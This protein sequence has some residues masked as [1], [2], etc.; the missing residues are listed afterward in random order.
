MHPLVAGFGYAVG[1]L[2]VI[3]GRAAVHRDDADRGHSGS[4]PP[5]TLDEALG[6]AS[7]LA[8]VLASNLAATW[9]FAAI[10][11]EFTICERYT[12]RLRTLPGPDSHRLDQNSLS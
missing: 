4:D 2:V 11:G 7:G 8:I 12:G 3:L 9:V 5:N 1:F 6:F 10:L